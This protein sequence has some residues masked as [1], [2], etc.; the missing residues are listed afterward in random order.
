ML[1]GEKNNN[2]NDNYNYNNN[3]NS[4]SQK[5]QPTPESQ[6]PDD[7]QG[8]PSAR[9]QHPPWTPL[10]TRVPKAARA[11]CAAVLLSLLKR[12]ISSQTDLEAWDILF[13]FAPPILSI[14]AKP[15]RIN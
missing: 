8:E 14:L 10:I 1:R 11:T 6:P 5:S 7:N 4:N 3:S 9:L 15:A 12:I 13:S 2:N